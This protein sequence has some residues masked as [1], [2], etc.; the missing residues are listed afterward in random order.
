[1]CDGPETSSESSIEVEAEFLTLL[2]RRGE[3]GAE[4]LM[5]R[6]LLRKLREQLRISSE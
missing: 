3:P 1:M 5:V 4:E 6:M 2:S